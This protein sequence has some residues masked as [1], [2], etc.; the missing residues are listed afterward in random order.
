M[1]PAT[2]ICQVTDMSRAVAFYRDVLGLSATLITPGWSQF[3]LAGL[4]L[5]LHPKYAEGPGPGA[6][7][8]SL[9][10]QVDDLAALRAGLLGS[11]VVIGK[12]SDVPGGTVLP[13]Q[14][15]DG[16]PIQAIQYG[17]TSAALA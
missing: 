3:D 5:G 9:G 12:L 2:M 10:I 17:I 14:D 11:G 16:N 13:F 6:G 15:P 8:W 7:G 1:K 4:S